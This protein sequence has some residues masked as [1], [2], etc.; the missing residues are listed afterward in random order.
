MTDSSEL[1]ILREENHRLRQQVEELS[2]TDKLTGMNNRRAL[3]RALETQVT[4]SRRYHNPLSVM[5][6]E[7]AI[8]GSMAG[9]DDDI[10]LAVSRFLGENLRWVDMI[11]R[12]DERQF[13]LVLPET[14]IEDGQRLLHKIRQGFSESVISKQSGAQP[15][16]LYVGLAEWQ[17]G[18]D[19]RLLLQRAMETLAGE[20]SATT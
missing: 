4:R 15:I 7:V 13:I 12:W 8:E 20:K 11:A 16:L 9:P 1:E 10:I 3:Q 14:A 17:K 18:D 6:I 5:L 2:I 19:V